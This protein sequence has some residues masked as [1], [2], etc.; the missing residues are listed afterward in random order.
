MVMEVIQ[1]ISE[2]TYLLRRRRMR[3]RRKIGSM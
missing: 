1:H 3:W 2:D